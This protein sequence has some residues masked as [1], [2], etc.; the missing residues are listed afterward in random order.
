[1]LRII[2]TSPETEFLIVECRS[3]LTLNIL[4]VG[5]LLAYKLM[6]FIMYLL[7]ERYAIYNQ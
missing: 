6:N 2:H 3:N 1:M 4:N 5:I 7:P